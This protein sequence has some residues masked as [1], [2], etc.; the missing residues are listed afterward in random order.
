MTNA[1]REAAVVWA[2]LTA[3]SF[4]VSMTGWACSGN[5]WEIKTSCRI[6]VAKCL[7]KQPLGIMNTKWE[8]NERF[9]VLTV[10]SLQILVFWYVMMCH[11]VK[12][13]P[14]FEGQQ[15]NY[16]PSNTL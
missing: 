7:E 6:V 2:T 9:E 14:S 5:D 15:K 1:T 11:L 3:E 10:V 4:F 12:I 16:L 13:T 8:N